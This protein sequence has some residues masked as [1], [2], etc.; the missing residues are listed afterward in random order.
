MKSTPP[1]LVLLLRPSPPQGQP[2]R[3]LD[4]PPTQGR[5]V[6][7]PFSSADVEG[8]VRSQLDWSKDME[9]LKELI[10]RFGKDADKL[11]FD[12]KMLEG[13]DPNNPFLKDLL[14]DWIKNQPP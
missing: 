6:P 8:I 14:K 13:I 5:Y 2:P 10:E 4:P 12:R 9:P 11:K 7:F 1:P 3:R